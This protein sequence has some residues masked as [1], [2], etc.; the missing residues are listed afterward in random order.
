MMLLTLSDLYS[1]PDNAQINNNG[2][3]DLKFSSV[4]SELNY[5][6]LQ[7]R[8]LWHYTAGSA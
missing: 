7:R 5:N 6:K 4:L 2:R 8:F 3:A 1:V